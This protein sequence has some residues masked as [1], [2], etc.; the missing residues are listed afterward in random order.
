MAPV[1]GSA[2][3]Y[4]YATLGEI[5]AWIIGWDLV[6]E[7]AMSCSVVASHWSNYFNE[8]V[9]DLVRPSSGRTRPT[10]AIPV[11]F[12]Y[13]PFTPQWSTASSCRPTSTCRPSLIM[14]LITIILVLG[15][16]ESATTN[17]V[18]V[19][20][21]IAVVLFVIALGCGLHQPRQLDENPRRKAPHHRRRSISSTGIPTSKADSR[22]VRS[23]CTTTGDELLENAPGTRQGAQRRA[24]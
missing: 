6:L 21:K 13:D 3:T 14:G 17:A 8:F 23:P 4:T 22:P 16:R 9:R 2:Y 1:A 5:W 10:W 7:Y 18:L 15:I 19:V 20:V 12:L 11:Q 24:S